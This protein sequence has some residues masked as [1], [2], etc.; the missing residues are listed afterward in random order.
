M[1]DL[2]ARRGGAVKTVT[3]MDLPAID[4][5]TAAYPS[6][7]VY[8]QRLADARKQGWLARPPLPN[9]VMVLDREGSEFFLR[10]KAT[11]SPGSY[12][13]DLLG[14]T[15]GPARELIDGHL[16]NHSGDDHRRL[17]SIA[18]QS[19]NPQVADSWRPA[20][21]TCLARVWSGVEPATKCEFVAAIRPYPS[22]TMATILGMPA[23]DAP[24]LDEWSNRAGQQ[25]ELSALAGELADIERA[26]AEV[27][28]YVEVLFEREQ[29][30]PSDSLVSS[31]LTAGTQQDRLSRNESVRLVVNMITA[32]IGTVKTALTHAL[33]LFAEHPDQ[34]TLLAQRPEMTA[35]AASEVLRF[36][37]PSPF[38]PQI[39][40]EELEYRDI[41]FPKGTI[42]VVCAERANRESPVRRTAM[43]EHADGERFDITVNRED[44]M[45]TFGA[46]PHHCPGSHVG[47]ALLEEALMFLAPRM[48]GLAL[49]G[50][51]EV[52]NLR[53]F[54]EIS[55]LPLRWTAGG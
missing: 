28:E 36:E 6:P 37:P 33:R 1:D 48:P 21:R 12:L 29:T 55:A 31:V 49:D 15:N 30:K 17:K 13:A 8:H 23:E 35:Q 42:V 14:V 16:L 46:G 7:D 39:C 44:R 38:I 54:Y 45:L 40:L 3:D 24:R 4:Y 20:M 27:H 9:V 11:T 5:Y 51:P 10:T 34:W 47:R 25:F 53:H 50:E 41:I 22:L 43:R 18:K 19:L 52:G 26:S 2:S 32:G